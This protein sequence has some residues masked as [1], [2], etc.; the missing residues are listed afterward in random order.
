MRRRWVMFLVLVIGL[1]GSVGPL[2]AWRGH[3]LGGVR[4][5]IGIGLGPFW[6]P[7]WVPY[8]APV[9]VPPPVVVTPIRPGD[10]PDGSPDLLVLL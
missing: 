2:Y 3:G 9:V 7:L 4:V 6:E 10:A 5:G 8:A 1:C